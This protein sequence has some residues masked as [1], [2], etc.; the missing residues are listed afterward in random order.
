MPS[1]L[2]PTRAKAL[3]AHSARIGQ[4]SSAV[5]LPTATAV[6]ITSAPAQNLPFQNL[7]GKAYVQQHA[8]EICR[9]ESPVVDR[10]PA[11]RDPQ[12]IR[13]TRSAPTRWAGDESPVEYIQS[14]RR[15]SF[16][17]ASSMELG[18]KPT[19]AGA[20]AA[21]TSA[22]G[23]PSSVGEPPAPAQ[24]KSSRGENATT[25]HGDG[26]L[27]SPESLRH[28]DERSIGDQSLHTVPAIDPSRNTQTDIGEGE[29]ESASERQAAMDMVDRA[30]AGQPVLSG[31]D[32]LG[33]AKSDPQH[34]DGTT[35]EGPA[36]NSS[37]QLQARGEQ[38]VSPKPVG[39][40]L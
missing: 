12:G 18:K 24:A 20:P 4:S 6:G 7:T 26:P 31:P 11:R 16:G 25:A 29:D 15:P 32:P 36:Q 30:N 1:Q 13:A 40:S 27:L 17:H 37:N 28:P 38:K 35:H 39:S 34:Q 5:Q 10:G 8:V 22:A 23:G 3:W 2:H 19:T 21:P 14:G 9:Q 33:L